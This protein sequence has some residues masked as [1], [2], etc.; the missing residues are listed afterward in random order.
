MPGV[1][2]PQNRT[3]FGLRGARG[4]FPGGGPGPGAAGSQSK[5]GAPA[6]AGSRA[7]HGENAPQVVLDQNKY[8]NAK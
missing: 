7:F 8:K 3:P 4:L 1:R 6:P 5:R 2:L